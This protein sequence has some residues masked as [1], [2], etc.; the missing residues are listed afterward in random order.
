MTGASGQLLKL[1]Q[2]GAAS[3]APWCARNRK[4]GCFQM[5]QAISTNRKTKGFRANIRQ[6]TDV[7]RVNRMPFNS[8]SE[9]R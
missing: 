9:R 5:K 8:N 2:T 7:N 6:Q 4:T 1:L 3:F